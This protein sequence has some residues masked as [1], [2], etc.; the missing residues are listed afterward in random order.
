VVIGRS[1][2]TAIERRK[3]AKGSSD[4]F[5][6]TDV[7]EKLKKSKLDQWLK[8]L[9]I[10]MTNPWVELGSVVTVHKQLMDL[11]FDITELEKRSLASKYLHFHRPDLF[12]I[13]DSRAK[14]AINKVTPRLNQIEKNIAAE[15]KDFEYHAF[16]RKAQYL[17]DSINEEFDVN[18]NSRQLD[19]ILLR[20]AD[21]IK[22][23]N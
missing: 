6:E 16:C 11:F 10:K 22:N 14:K 5:Y 21:K 2:A 19:K 17:K 12:F 4:N 9:P 7:V 1:Y 20:I 18:L 13:Y 3:N 8:D 15:N 23:S